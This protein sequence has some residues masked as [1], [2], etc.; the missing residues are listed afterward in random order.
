MEQS[1]NEGSQRIIATPP[2]RLQRF[3]IGAA[4]LALCCTEVQSQCDRNNC[5]NAQPNCSIQFAGSVYCCPPQDSICGFSIP[6]GSNVVTCTCSNPLPT[7]PTFAPSVTPGPTAC[8]SVVGTWVATF[9]EGNTTVRSVEEKGQ[10][11]CISQNGTVR[12]GQ[13]WKA[14]GCLMPHTKRRAGSVHVL[15]H[16]LER[17]R[18]HQQQYVFEW[19]IW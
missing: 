5:A 7:P 11:Y 8:N 13:M 14:M 2:S 6:A 17:S 15:S 16:T 4:L 3:L 9:P 12:Y 18:T 10:G 1:C 19:W